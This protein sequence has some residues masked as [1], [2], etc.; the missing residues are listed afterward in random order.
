MGKLLAAIGAISLLLVACSAEG[1]RTTPS[2]DGI[3]RRV[4]EENVSRKGPASESSH[5][6][7]GPTAPDF[8]ITTFDGNT[9][10][11][12]EQRGTPVVLNF[13]ESW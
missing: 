5:R 8:T 4:D 13:W 3:Q 2:A 10:N 6:S 7:A 11:L 12:R 1:T 9:F